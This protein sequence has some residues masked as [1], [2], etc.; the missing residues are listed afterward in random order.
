MKK[1]PFCAED[2][3]DAAIKC[4]H[5]GERLDMSLGTPWYY[6]TTSLIVSFLCVGPFMLP[7]VWLNPEL[8]HRKKVIYSC[9]I[10]IF[11]LLLIWSTVRSV[12]NIWEYYK[13]LPL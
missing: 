12:Q 3:Q 10:V 6:S 1:C 13:M 9:I 8:D 7:L 4:K 2:I 11:S 5:C